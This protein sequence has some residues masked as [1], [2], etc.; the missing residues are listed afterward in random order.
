MCHTVSKAL[1]PSGGVKKCAATASPRG[2]TGFP[3][4]QIAWASVGHSDAAW[5]APDNEQT[6]PLV[7]AAAL[8]VTAAAPHIDD[9]MHRLRH[10]TARVLMGAREQLAIIRVP[11]EGR[12]VVMAAVRAQ[13]QQRA[14]AT[15]T[16]LWG[17]PRSPVRMSQLQSGFRRSGLPRWGESLQRCGRCGGCA[18]LP[19]AAAQACWTTRRRR[20]SSSAEYDPETPQRMS[21]GNI[22]HESSPRCCSSR[23][24]AGGLRRC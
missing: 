17:R 8:S 1:K 13:A 20:R 21:V 9:R 6:P 5:A 24:G 10:E 11:V 3:T 14:A 18:A 12:D 22:P 19:S 23:A 7:T 4:V 16:R 2:A 15:M